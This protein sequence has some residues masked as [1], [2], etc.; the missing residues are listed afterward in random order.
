MVSNRTAQW[1]FSFQIYTPHFR[2]LFQ[3]AIGVHFKMG[4]PIIQRL[5]PWYQIPEILDLDNFKTTR[6]EFLNIYQFVYFITV[7]I[8]L[9]LIRFQ[10]R[11]NFS[12]YVLGWKKKISSPF[13]PDAQMN[14]K[15]PHN[16]I[17]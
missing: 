4:L 1:V 7:I 11:N 6:Y 15:I 2:K 14:Y 16:Y 3:R 8:M 13:K 12:L 5:E 9:I 10:L 17:L